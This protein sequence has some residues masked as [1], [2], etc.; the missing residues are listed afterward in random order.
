GQ[1]I[2]RRRDLGRTGASR[3]RQ[4]GTLPAASAAARQ[5]NLEPTVTAAAAGA[6]DREIVCE[7][8]RRKTMEN[9]GAGG[10]GPRGWRRPRGI[11]R[12][13][14]DDG[15]LRDDASV[16]TAAGA[17]SD[18]DADADDRPPERQRRSPWCTT[19]D[20]PAHEATDF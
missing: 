9:D 14:R 13:V 4:R 6:I 19:A 2:A 5:P 3:D 20:R 15:S 16:A 7:R 1:E 12:T 10:H 11:A 17:R 8:R 18:D